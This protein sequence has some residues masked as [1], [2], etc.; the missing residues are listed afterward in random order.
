MAGCIQEKSYLESYK[1]ETAAVIKQLPSYYSPN[2]VRVEATRRF[3][4]RYAMDHASE[5]K[6]I[7]PTDEVSMSAP[8][9][10]KD[11][12]IFYPTYGEH[13]T[14]LDTLHQN[15][16]NYSD[17]YSLSDHQTSRLA[18]EAFRNG[19]TIAVLS[20]AR[21]GENN[22]DLLMMTY[23]HETK[24]GKTFVV[25]TAMDG[26]YHS[27]NEIITIGQKRFDK[28][29]LIQPIDTSAILTD[30]SLSPNQARETV[31]HV[32]LESERFT[33][34]TPHV[35]YVSENRTNLVNTYPY[36]SIK[37]VSDIR[38]TWGDINDFFNQK[39][40]KKKK[41]EK[42]ETLSEVEQ[43]KKL[44][45]TKK[46]VETAIT[47]FSEPALFTL[48]E[49]FATIGILFAVD[50]L[51]RMPEESIP[52]LAFKKTVKLIDN[53]HTR[54]VETQN[55]IS[56]VGIVH[57]ISEKLIESVVSQRPLEETLH[58]PDSEIMGFFD[59]YRFFNGEKQ[60]LSPKE[61]KIK[62]EEGQ[63][64]NKRFLAL[65]TLEEQQEYHTLERLALLYIAITMHYI[66]PNE[67]ISENN[68]QKKLELDIPIARLSQVLILLFLFS[69]TSIFDRLFQNKKHGDLVRKH[70]KKQNL[71]NLIIQQL[72]Q[73]PWILLSIIWYLAIIRE[74]EIGINKISNSGVIFAF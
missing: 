21:E 10:L 35:P 51:A 55:D 2:D 40:G 64:S 72:K 74:Q 15:Q 11:G 14:Y 60:K 66:K 65:T 56:Q 47:I 36:L 46:D 16:K 58:I 24:E 6:D 18:E 37:V 52:K 7:N 53:T 71:K 12:H 22:R 73:T 67:F 29:S 33:T 1:A 4:I 39:W 25:N 17:S 13:G 41:H 61:R 54:S 19:A 8:F 62:K 70:S 69:Y 44:P 50:T 5:A 49:P 9:T 23:D 27:Y 57:Q 34:R 32:T 68:K 63:K 42:D 38:E 26:K 3:K 48:K 43:E 45:P 30:T 31:T 59:L 20:Y 28:L